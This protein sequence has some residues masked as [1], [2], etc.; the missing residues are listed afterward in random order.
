M[1]RLSSAATEA[2]VIALAAVAVCGGAFAISR[3]I[4]DGTGSSAQL[5]P[6][7]DAN[8]PGPDDTPVPGT[9]PDTSKPGWAIP[10]EN[11]ER[12]KPR[13]DQVI[14]GIAVGPTVAIPDVPDCEQGE[15][16]ALADLAVAQR[17]D[18]RIVPDF[19]PHGAIES[20][21]AAISCRDI[22]TVQSVTY[23]VPAAANADALIKSGQA[24]WEDV[25]T[26]G[27]IDVVRSRAS[28]PSFRS[29]NFAAERWKART[30]NGHA[31]AVAEPALAIGLGRSAVVVWDAEHG[32]LTVL[33]A[34]NRRLDELVRVAEGLK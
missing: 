13:Y 7:T 18:L 20:R 25:E 22:V 21:R 11:A 23:E 26:G 31:A 28:E 27:R 1:P 9:T 24:K 2:L 8:L 30:L 17:S 29:T 14:N 10:Y 33:T 19:L 3:Y 32:V 15:S 6:P 5:A 16:I 12:D 34:S 4:G